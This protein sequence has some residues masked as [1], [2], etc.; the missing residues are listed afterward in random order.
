MIAFGGAAPQSSHS[1]P[2]LHPRSSGV[3]PNGAPTPIK[4]TEMVPN[5]T[6]GHPCM[7]LPNT[8]QPSPN[9]DRS[10]TT[11]SYPT[12]ERY[13]V[14]PYPAGIWRSLPKAAHSRRELLSCSVPLLGVDFNE[15]T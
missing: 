3:L 5:G 6:R 15:E 8:V 10:D 14:S 7:D 1:R 9:R 11:A 12:R 2:V 13:F 4:L